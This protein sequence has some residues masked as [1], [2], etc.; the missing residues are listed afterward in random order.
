MTSILS[1]YHRNIYT[2]DVAIGLKPTLNVMEDN[3]HHQISMLLVVDQFLGG[4]HGQEL[5][6]Y[7]YLLYSS[8][9]KHMHHAYKVVGNDI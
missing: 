1:L 7:S 6:K 4:T 9:S 2:H 5:S 3:L 8:K